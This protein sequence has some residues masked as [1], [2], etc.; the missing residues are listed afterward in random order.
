[1]SSA[2]LT[3]ASRVTFKVYD[4]SGTVLGA[5]VY[6]LQI[7][8]CEPKKKRGAVD[9]TNSES[10][11][12]AEFAPGTLSGE[13]SLEGIVDVAGAFDQLFTDVMDNAFLCQV[14][15]WVTKAANGNNPLT[16]AGKM[17]FEETGMQDEVTAEGSVLKFTASTKTIGYLTK[18]GADVT[19]VTN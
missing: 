11:G 17:L 14:T 15:F 6:T 5:Q 19:S 8:K 12:A 3:F 18:G 7:T 9:F 13:W 4:A 10:G 1:M 2:I 16:Y